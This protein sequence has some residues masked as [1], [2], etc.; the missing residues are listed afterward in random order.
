MPHDFPTGGDLPWAT[1]QSQG[2]LDQE[3]PKCME[4][5]HHIRGGQID[6]GEVCGDGRDRFRLEAIA[7]VPDQ[8]PHGHREARTPAG[9]SHD[10]LSVEASIHAR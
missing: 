5:L 10:G 1:H 9:G 7:Q 6:V 3:E 4:G 2:E 8:L